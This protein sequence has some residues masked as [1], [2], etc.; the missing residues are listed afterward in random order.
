MANIKLTAENKQLIWDTLISLL[1]EQ[2]NVSIEVVKERGVHE[3]IHHR[4]HQRDE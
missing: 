2:E 4:T 1:E 3:S